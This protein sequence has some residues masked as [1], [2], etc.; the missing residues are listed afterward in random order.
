MPK[1]MELPSFSA[2]RF[3]ITPSIFKQLNGFIHIRKSSYFTTTSLSTAWKSRAG[4]SLHRGPCERQFKKNERLGCSRVEASPVSKETRGNL[5]G[6]ETD[7][8]EDEDASWPEDE[9]EGWGFP[10]SQF[11]NDFKLINVRNDDDED[12]LDY[13]TE[14][15]NELQVGSVDVAVK[16]IT[17]KDWEDVVFGDI[18]PLVVLVYQRYDRPIEN[19]KVRKEL[20]K[21]INVFW[22]SDKA[23]PRAVKFEATEETKLAST[24]NVEETPVVIFIKDGKLVHRQK[25]ILVADDLAKIMAYFYYGANQPECLKSTKLSEEEVPSLA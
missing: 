3:Q 15:E 6:E 12:D 22:D 14:D 10:L 4:S 5:K 20:E 23:A 9:E 1:T 24:L 25:E 18:S 19:M 16:D 21:A 8:S 13:L 17:A 7:S 2:A 11:F